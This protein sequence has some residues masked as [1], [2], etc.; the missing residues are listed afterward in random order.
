M[1]H[2]RY[3]FE[4]PKRN[5]QPK[6]KRIQANVVLG[7]LSKKCKGMGICTI[8]THTPSDDSGSIPAVFHLIEDEIAITFE[9]SALSSQNEQTYFGSAY[10]QLEEN[11]VLPPAVIQQLEL[12]PR[13]LKAGFYRIEEKR[14]NYTVIFEST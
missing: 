10:F 12:T 13:Q 6:A 4:S 14:H 7:V 1:E 2:T 9:K 3:T 11:V 5:R 8:S